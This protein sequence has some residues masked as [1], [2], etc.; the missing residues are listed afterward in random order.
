MGCLT[1]VRE[2]IK[3]NDSEEYPAGQI[4]DEM[5]RRGRSLI[6]EDEEIE[7]LADMQ[8]GKQ[9]YLRTAF[10]CFFPFVD[11]RHHFHV[12][13]VFPKTRFTPL[14]LRES[15]VPDDKINEFGQIKDGLANLQLLPGLENSEKSSTMPA[16]WLKETYSDP[17]NRQEYQDRHLLGEVS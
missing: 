10:R 12:D 4:Y 14:R 7:D 6:F 2:I 11:L 13:H 15:N 17:T 3:Q 5:A 9:A 8:Y 16:E 1:A